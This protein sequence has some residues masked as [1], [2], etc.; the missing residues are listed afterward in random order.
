MVD[1][2]TALSGLAYLMLPCLVLPFYIL[3][4]HVM[5]TNTSVRRLASNRLVTQLNVADCIQLVLHSSS[6]IFV[7]FPRIAENNIYIVRTVGALINAAWLV[8]FPILCLLAVT[9]ILI[10]YQYASPLNTIGV[11]K[12]CTACCS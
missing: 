11:M 10:I 1:T 8:T 12:K 5:V 2:T 9:R 7:L 3:L 6:G 4:T